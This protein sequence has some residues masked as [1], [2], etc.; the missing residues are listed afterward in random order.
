[1][2]LTFDKLKEQ[3]KE[4]VSQTGK[5]KIVPVMVKKFNDSSSINPF[6]NPFQNQMLV[7]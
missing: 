2:N 1:M 3:Q 5:K 4:T 6:M 7:D